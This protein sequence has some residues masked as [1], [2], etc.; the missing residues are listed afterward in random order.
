MVRAGLGRA[1]AGCLPVRDGTVLRLPVSVT[2]GPHRLVWRTLAGGRTAPGHRGADRGAGGGV[3]RLIPSLVAAR[4]AALAALAGDQLR[5]RQ[6][7]EALA[8]GTRSRCWRRRAAASRRRPRACGARPSGRGSR[9][10]PRSLAI[11]VCCAAGRCRRSPSASPTSAAGCGDLA[12]RHDFVVLQLVRL[13]PHLRDVGDAPLVVDL[14]TACRSTRRR[15][16][17]V[18][19]LLL[20]PLLAAEARRLAA[21]EARLVA[22]ARTALVVCERDRQVLARCRAG[23][24]RPPGGGADRCLDHAPTCRGG[25]HPPSAREP[26]VMLTGNLGYFPNRDALRFFLDEVWPR[27]R[28]AAPGAAFVSPA[29]VRHRR[30]HGASRAAGGT[31]VAGPPTC[32]SL[33]AGAT[34]AVAP[35][36]CGSGVPLKVLDAWAAG[37]PVVASPFAAAGVDAEPGGDLLVADTP[38][39]VGRRRCGGARRRRRCATRARR[40]RHGAARRAR[41]RSGSIRGCGGWSP[42]A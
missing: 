31:L 26:T 8:P 33:L 36:R 22:A 30:R 39:G 28:A 27:L 24:R 35:L 6:L 3:V 1:G 18:D 2:A 20:R 13:L 19:R 21:A 37:V 4:A 14:S 17:G 23:A 41:A 29:I 10:G 9:P 42:A 15:A 25:R 5:A 12:P 16:R 32:A 7:V 11:P 40:R 38:R 34:V